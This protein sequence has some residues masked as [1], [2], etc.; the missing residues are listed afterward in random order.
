MTSTLVI[1]DYFAD[2][3]QPCRQLTPLLHELQSTYGFT[4]NKINVDDHQEEA[5]EKGVMSIPT[6]IITNNGEVV[7]RI[8]G[9][10]N[11]MKLESLIKKYL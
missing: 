6:L 1:N 11:K 10:Q 5:V 4:L 8:I 7:E 3:C 2:W 9:Y